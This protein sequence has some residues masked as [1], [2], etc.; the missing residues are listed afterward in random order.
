MARSAVRN[1]LTIVGILA[2][3]AAAALVAGFALFKPP[4]PSQPSDALDKAAQYGEQVHKNIDD[5]HAAYDASLREAVKFPA[6]GPLK[7]LFIGDSLTAGYFSSTQDKGYSQLVVAELQKKGAVERLGG[8]K[9][10]GNLS[11]V[12]NLVSIPQGFNIAVVELGTNDIQGKTD[13]AVFPGQYEE[14][15]KKVQTAS[16]DTALLCIGTWGSAG[17]DTDAYD[18]AIK[19]SCESHGGKYIDV[20]SEFAIASNRGPAGV[21]GWAGVSD[22][23]HPNDAGH[24]RLAALVMDHLAV[25]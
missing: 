18:N 5:A 24:A 21:T 25:S 6:S 17:A 10:G 12:G 13:A 14:L 19:A 15:L 9:A 22:N 4:A 2:L 8:S 11:T 16:P 23:F 3:A 7:V 20:S 1:G